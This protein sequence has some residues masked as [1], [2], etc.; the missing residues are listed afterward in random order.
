[1]TTRR[2]LRSSVIKSLSAALVVLA[3]ASAH[4]QEY[5]KLTLEAVSG[6]KGS[7]NFSAPLPP[8]RWARDGIHIEQ[9]VGELVNWLDPKTLASIEPPKEPEAPQPSSDQAALKQAFEK[10]PGFDAA[11]AEK[12]M[13]SRVASAADG[14]MLFRFES[15]LFFWKP[16]QDCALRLTS[17]PE[18][19]E[20]P[21]LSA[22]G[23]FASF[24]RGGDFFLCD[25]RSAKERAITTDGSESL[26][27]GM[28]DWVYQEEVFGRGNFDGTFWSPTSHHVSILVLDESPVFEF[29][30]VDHLP[31]RLDVEQ[32]PYPKSGDPNP[33]VRLAVVKARSG[34]LRWIDL[35]RYEGGEIL[36]VRVGWNPDGSRLVLL[37][38]D[39]EQRWLDLDYA[40]PDSGK[41]TH[42]F[43]ESSP[44][45]VD[46]PEMPRWMK[47]GSFLW[48]SERTGYR[49][50]YRYAADGKLLHP[51]TSGEW[52]LRSVQEVDETNGLLYFTAA[53]DSAIG[54]HYYRTRLDGSELKSLT[55]EPGTHSIEW[56]G[57]RTYFL[58]RFSSL[59]TPPEVRLCNAD[60][61][62]R[63]ILCKVDIPAL[64]EYRYS[65]PELL[66]I[67][68]RDGFKMDATLIKPHDFDPALQYPI[69]LPTYSGPDAPSVRNAWSGSS[70][71]QFLAQEGILVLQVNNKSSSTKGKC[72]V[73]A[74]Y[75][76]FGV[77]ELKD[78]EDA[79]DHVCENAWA[80]PTRVG[81]TGWSYGG[82]MT[83]FALTH[84]SKFA[85]GIAGAGV[86]DWRLYDTIYTERYMRTPQNNPEG[87]DLTSCIKAAPDLHGHLVLIHGTM[88][89]N[90]HFQNS[91]QMAYALQKAGKQF[92]FMPYAGSRHG[93][94]D[95]ELRWHQ[96]VLAWRAI[97]EHLLRRPADRD[98][99]PGEQAATQ[100]PSGDR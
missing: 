44:T 31:N 77:E 20:N 38:Q 42:L 63:T 68:N 61:E 30:V 22:D 60:G 100:G 49:H 79:L 8:T 95:P 33:A 76:R 24:T 62:V 91:I 92:D 53:L 51:V 59:A 55:P 94:G 58:D 48:E 50:L 54:T 13:G 80:D 82:F 56:N 5:K 65:T 74:C 69:W 34:S 71:D 36:I 90:V 11:S 2:W 32:T 37:V 9:R 3:T 4:S 98:P 86:Y 25:T 89:D 39:R 85:L 66:E 1:M 73:D 96:R 67:E 23:K 15:D 47:D 6:R 57:A 97:E 43:R 17:S 7:V 52:P 72:T 26:L 18:I 75:Q 99:D 93:V 14:V 16:D 41:L 27:Y 29:T 70:F 45:W 84:S 28:L 88:D 83:A 35:S 12:A 46:I 64:K 40:D 87:Y 21:E 78:L 81:I 19:E 10:L